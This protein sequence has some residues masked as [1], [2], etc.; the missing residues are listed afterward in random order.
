VLRYTH[1]QGLIRRTI[2][3]DELF[4]DTDLGD[5]AGAEEV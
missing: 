3:L 2:S 1:Q 4:E 5:A